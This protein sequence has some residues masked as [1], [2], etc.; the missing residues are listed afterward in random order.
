MCTDKGK[1]CCKETNKKVP[2][3]AGCC[4]DKGCQEKKEPCCCEETD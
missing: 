3:S 1:G 4:Q 2:T